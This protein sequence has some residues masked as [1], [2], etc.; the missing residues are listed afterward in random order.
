VPK[1]QLAAAATYPAR[2]AGASWLGYV[3]ANLPARRA[4]ATRRVGDQAAGFGTVDLLTLGA[5][6]RRAAD[7]GNSFTFDPAA[8]RLRGRER[9]RGRVERHSY[10]RCS[11]TTST[12]ER[13]C[14]PSRPG[15]AATGARRRFP[16]QPAAHLRLELAHQVPLSA[17]RL[18]RR[19]SGGLPWGPP[20][21]FF[22]ARAIARLP[23]V[24]K[25]DRNRRTL[26]RPGVAAGGEPERPFGPWARRA[27][28]ISASWE[29]P[30]D[31]AAR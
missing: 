8:A 15:A 16:G 23:R 10:I 26:G 22:R 3:T 9:A 6:H 1:I 28:A 19:S 2:R 7:A 11:S 4:R 13:R 17:G 29:R 14:W 12:D 25:A 30:E 24:R 5:R 20:V 27:S 18:L 31:P 21:V